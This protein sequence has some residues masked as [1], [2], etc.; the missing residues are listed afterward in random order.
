[1]KEVY[2]EL[3]AQYKELPTFSSIN[4]EFRIGSM[5]HSP[6]P[7]D[8]LIKRILNQ[9]EA[10][11]N[12][13]QP[14]VEPDTNSMLGMYEHSS[15]S[16]EHRIACTEMYKTISYLERV[17][18]ASALSRD[19]QRQTVAIIEAT[20]AHEKIRKALVPYLEHFAD[21]WLE[22]H[23]SQSQPDYLG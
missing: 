8:A 23:G 12:L 22:D 20:R 17:L 4:K 3:R 16:E 11:K 15:T 6:F 5:G 14:I 2:K 13:L 18:Q 10:L 19:K 7:F 21:V 9:F 1:M